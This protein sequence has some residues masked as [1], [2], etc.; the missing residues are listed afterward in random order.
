M[1][2]NDTNAFMMYIEKQVNAKMEIT[3]YNLEHTRL[4][5]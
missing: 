2:K 1:I 4:C 5:T 3:Y